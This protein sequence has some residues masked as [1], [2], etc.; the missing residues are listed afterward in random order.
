VLLGA[1]K[2]HQIEENLGALDLARRLDEKTMAE[3]DE[4]LGNVPTQP[5]SYGRECTST[6]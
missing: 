4:I 5:L 6:L 3:I 1:T 2:M